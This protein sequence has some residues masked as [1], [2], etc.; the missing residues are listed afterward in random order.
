MVTK[1][2]AQLA[3]SLRLGARE[4]ARRANTSHVTVLKVLAGKGQPFYSKATEERVKSVIDA[5]AGKL[6][7]S[8]NKLRGFDEQGEPTAG[9]RAPKLNRK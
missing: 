6:Q 1:N 7:A 4:I 9:K 8:L 3:N 2:Y 5:E